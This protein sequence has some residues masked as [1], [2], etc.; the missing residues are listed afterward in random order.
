MNYASHEHH[1]FMGASNQALAD[2]PLQSALTR[3]TDTLMAGNRRGYAALAESPQLRD[4]AKR[5]KEH[6][7]A[8]LHHYLEMLEASVLRLGGHVH[9]AANAEEAR[10][11]IVAIARQAG[12]KKAVKSKSM[13][14]EEIHLNHALEQ[15]G[16]EVAETDYGE[17][18]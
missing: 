11:A 18:I 5:I 13:T 14:S 12:C 17:F 9:W 6:T 4:H 16:I 8:H 2:A 3:L 10:Q 1:D 15:A 7:L